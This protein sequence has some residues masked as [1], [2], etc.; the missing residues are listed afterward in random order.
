MAIDDELINEIRQAG[1]FVLSQTAIL[2]PSVSVVMDG[3]TKHIVELITAAPEMD[4]GIATAIGNTIQ[5]G[6]WTSDQKQTMATAVAMRLQSAKPKSSTSRTKQQ[7]L[8]QGFTTYWTQEFLSMIQSKSIQLWTK[9]QALATLCF[10][11]GL[12]HPTEKT[13]RHIIQC[14]V[15]FGMPENA[16]DHSTLYESSNRFKKELKSVRQSASLPFAPPPLY[17]PN[18]Y[19]GLPSEIWANVWPEGQPQPLGN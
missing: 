8:L 18:P 19:D 4:S 9:I 6:P 17:P 2:G 14:L 1:A 16:G 7:E 11:L 13:V 5:A 15:F 10:A 3:Q 12:W